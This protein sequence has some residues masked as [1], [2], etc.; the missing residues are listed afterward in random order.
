MGWREGGDKFNVIL[1]GER[2]EA[3]REPD[4]PQH[5]GSSI[6]SHNK[7]QCLGECPSA[8]MDIMAFGASVRACI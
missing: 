7:A 5:E 8:T 4:K 6:N 2:S 3:G 1:T